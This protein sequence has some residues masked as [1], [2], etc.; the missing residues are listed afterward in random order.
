MVQFYFDNCVVTYRCLHQA[1]VVQWAE[2]LLTNVETARPWHYEVGHARA[3]IIITILAIVTLRQDKIRNNGTSDVSHMCALGDAFFC[4]ATSLTDVETGLPTLASAQARILHVLYLL[5]TTR[6]NQAWYVFGGLVPIVSALGL[7][8]QSSF[9]HRTGGPHT[10]RDDFI[11]TQCRKRTF[12]VCYTIDKYLAVV[13]GRPRLYHDDDINQ[14]FPDCINDEDMTTEGKADTEPSIDCH[15][16]SLIAHAKLAQLIDRISR[17][18][19]SVKKVPKRERLAS[20]QRLGLELHEWNRSLPSHLG[21]VRIRSL[22]PPFRRQA[23]ALKLA[24][25]HAIMHANRPFLLGA[26][27]LSAAQRNRVS[28]VVSGTKDL[29]DMSPLASNAPRTMT[30]QD[31]ISECL[32]AAKVALELVDSMSPDGALFHAFWWTPYVTFCALAVVYVWEIQQQQFPGFDKQGGDHP[33]TTNH[34]GLSSR[35]RLQGLLELAQRCQRHL[36]QSTS[37]DSPSHR[38]S[39][40]L[41]ELR[42]EAKLQGGARPV[43]NSSTNVVHA[44][45]EIAASAMLADGM[46]PGMS[47]DF[48]GGNSGVAGGTFVGGT[49]F[50]AWQTRD[51][52]DLD[53]SAFGPYPDFIH[54]PMLPLLNDLGEPAFQPSPQI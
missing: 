30:L 20:A 4:L 18:V 37:A 52:M 17:E 13:F 38:Y 51:W 46:P 33:A 48:Y 26:A 47:Q 53:S 29:P 21:T 43:E 9:K 12:W 1:T 34:A 31:S 41:E 50:D 11:L 3:S 8:R 28:S 40:I 14:G 44:A 22:I 42:K 39:V 27:S 6:M 23:S 32:G 15:V 36:S 2:A 35:D 7:H 45:E 5:Q 25:C 49:I 24:Y 16:D 19:Y 10:P 54:G